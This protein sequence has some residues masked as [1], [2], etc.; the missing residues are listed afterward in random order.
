MPATTPSEEDAILDKLITRDGVF[1]VEYQKANEEF[2]AFYRISPKAVGMLGY[3]SVTADTA[4][5][6]YHAAFA[7]LIANKITDS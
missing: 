4:S 7:A 3:D 5:E 6:A 1:A 2:R